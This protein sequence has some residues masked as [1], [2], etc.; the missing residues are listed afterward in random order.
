MPESFARYRTLLL[1]ATAAI[2]LSAVAVAVARPGAPSRGF[3]SGGVVQLRSDSRILDVA[4]ASDGGMVV[5]GE[6]GAEA[7]H[8]RLL[9]QRLTRRGKPD[10]RFRGGKPFLGPPGTVA[11]AV[12]V[13]RDGSIVVAG[14][15]TGPTGA[16]HQGMIVMRLK[17]NGARDRSFGGDGAV[18]AFSKTRGQGLAVAVYRDGRVLVAGASVPLDHRDGFDRVGLARFKPTGRRDRSFG[19]RGAA[20]IDL[21]RF[22]VAEDVAVSRGGKIV[23]AGSQRDNLQV[24]VALAAR[25]HAN[26]A[27]DRGFGGRGGFQRQLA[28]A[29]SA[30]SAFRSLAL[31]KGGQVVLAGTA[32]STQ[33]GPEAVVVQLGNRGRP[34]RSFGGDGVVYLPATENPNQYNPSPLAGAFG[35]GLQGADI[36]LAGF[37]DAQGLKELALWALKGNGRPD[38]RFGRGGHV[39]RRLGSDSAAFNGIAVS[40]AHL[41]AGGEAGAVLGG[42]SRGLVARYQGVPRG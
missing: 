17:P 3:G 14:T 1:L 23:I 15:F 10:P 11:N 18:S 19:R 40:G 24:T 36:V 4:A 31:R 34:T 37:H 28:K 25:L 29:G 2:V 21:G 32:G 22:S 27:L 6:A 16:D 39:F 8:A 9:V 13:R 41:L 38:R 7:R 5:V 33:E 26:G 35:V 12:A 30:F 20:V 42:Q